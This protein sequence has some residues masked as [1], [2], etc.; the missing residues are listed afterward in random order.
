MIKAKQPPGIPIAADPD[1][2]LFRAN[3][4]LS[5]TNESIA[6]FILLMVTALF[7]SA[8]PSWINISAWVYVAARFGHMLC[9]YADLRLARSA[10]FALSL[11]ALCSLF[12]A[13]FMALI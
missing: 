11:L 4:A 7:A 6:V 1:R 10:H 9:Y 8:P 5:N 3:R 13:T 2:F 12:V